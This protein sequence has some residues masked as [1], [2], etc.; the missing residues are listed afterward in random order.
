MSNSVD[1]GEVLKP[2]VMPK[3][4][5]EIIRFMSVKPQ[6]M[7]WG[8]VYD[9]YPIELRD[10][11]IT[12]LRLTDYIRTILRENDYN[13]I[14]AYE[15]LYGIRL[16]EGDPE[17][18]KKITREQTKGDAP[19]IATP[20]RMAEIAELLSSSKETGSAIILNFASRIADIAP[21]DMQEFSYRMFRLSQRATPVISGQSPHPKFN[22]VIW[23]LDKE[24][25]IPPWYT[26]DN[27]RIRML[28]IPRPD[29]FLRKTVID[30]LAKAIDGFKETD[31][32]KQQE[33]ISTFIDQTSGLFASEIVAIV[34]MA[35][36]Q[37]LRFA[38]ISDAIKAYKLGIVE[39]PWSRLDMQKIANSCATLLERVKGQDEAVQRSCDIIRRAVFNLSGC[40]Y[41]RHSQRPK[42]ALFFAGPTGVGKTE[43]AKAITAL[44]FGSETSYLRFD[45]SEYAREHSD[46]RLVGSPPGYVGY[47]VGGQLT[48]AIKNNPFCVI[49]FDEIEKAHPKILDIFLQILDDG[50]LTSGRGETVYFSESLIIFTSNLGIYETSETGQRLQRV[51]ADMPYEDINAQ[52]RQA[53]GDFFTYTIGRPEILNRIGDNIVVFDFIRAGAASLILDKMLQ[54]VLDKIKDFYGIDVTLSQRAYQSLVEITCSDLSMGG[55]GIGNKLESAFINPFSR[56]LFE[57][58][59]S[60]R[61]II[62]EVTRQGQSWKLT[63]DSQLT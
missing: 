1:Q 34:A 57:L 29:Y 31:A 12:T 35:R 45:M 42:G 47:D 8:N 60:K 58:Q 5:R 17:V 27:A 18:F 4:A 11:T 46:Q 41:S 37:Q 55:R 56:A 63:I 61:L 48:N 49:L 13:L 6:F 21:N 14:L 39:N 38:Q 32:Q 16:I 9:A 26:I 10:G 59:G 3:W 2:E 20:V 43:L 33:G 51:S 24:N 53:I 23:V 52:I 36:R 19:L 25:D 30:T 44:L 7:L 40:Q 15:P 54:N 62:T 28:N 50:R 22:L